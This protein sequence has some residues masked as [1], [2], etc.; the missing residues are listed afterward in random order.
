MKIQ[1]KTLFSLIIASILLLPS[2]TIPNS[3][4]ADGMVIRPDPYSDRWDY[5]DE[6][7]QQAFINY[8]DG[9][10]KMILSIGMEE[11]SENAVW[12]F[13]VPS[14]PNK[15]VIDMITQF[16][17]LS[18]EE[19][20]KK[21]K[22]N[23]FNIKK[24]LSAT[25]IYTIP[26]ID[27]WG[28]GYQGYQTP[29]E[30]MYSAPLG[31]GGAIATDIIVHEHLE[32]KGITTEIITAKTA[33]SLY[34]YL[35]NK[36][37]KVEEG[38]IPVLDHYI[39]KEFTFVVSWISETATT[40]PKAQSKQR[41]VFVTFPA[42]EIYYPL[43]PT[44]V[45]ESEIVPAT[46]RIIGHKSPKI[47]ED[48]KNYTET[49][50]FINSYISLGE[51]LE[52][53]YNGSTKNVKYTKIEIKAP[54]KFLVD[55]LWI[56]TVAPVKTYYSSFIAQ[57]ALS[58]GI[59]LLILSSVITCMIAGWII[60]R[61]LR[62]KNGIFKLALIGLSNCLS[63]IG[64]VVATVLF[65]TKA[66]DE[67]VASLLNEIRQKGYVR[68]RRLAVILFFAALSFLGLGSLALPS[69]IPQITRYGI[70]GSD[71]ISFLIIY[72]IPLLAL[73]FSFLIIKRIKPEDK[74][75]FAQLRSAGYSSWSFNP[76]DKMKFIFVPLFS[77]SFLLISWLIVKLVELTV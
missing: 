75:L 41:G 54:S 9:L 22:S 60:F 43:L 18:G 30:G 63:I 52:N 70:N 42:Q 23:L 66:K 77:V 25:Q 45:Y 15:V 28:M 13:P 38:S 57:H 53:F 37:L 56:N 50:Y 19:I 3:A 71:I 72:I 51:G 36:N 34:Q 74:P 26:F 67:N 49:E 6:S 62:S 29:A 16:P 31:T 61:D 7:N 35:Q 24:I 73:S 47:F 20:A 40:T 44:S 2:L 12:I 69:F 55:D 68:K 39:G 59:L 14:E 11:T 21:A 46:I 8:E 58:S 32:K 27:W 33:Q 1:L 17:K 10:E 4:L 64:L 48:I 5:L 76:K 65:R